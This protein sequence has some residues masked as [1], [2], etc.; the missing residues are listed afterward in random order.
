MKKVSTIIAS[1]TMLFLVAIA[2]ASCG[3]ALPSSSYEK[4]QFAFNGVEK[5]LKSVKLSSD[6]IN[7]NK[8]NYSKSNI[9]L[10]AAKVNADAYSV[11]ENLYEDSD[12]QGDIID[13]LEYNQ[14]PMIQ[15][16]YLKAILDDTGSDFE[17]GT[18]YYSNITN[19]IYYDIETGKKKANTETNYK[20]DYD[21]KLALE[22]NIDSNDLITCD[23]SFDVKLTKGST[24][25]NMDWYVGMELDYD[26]YDKNPNYKLNMLTDD[27]NIKGE[28]ILENDYVEVKNSKI[29]E[30]RK[31]VLE[32][33]RK[34]VKDSSHPNFDSYINEGIEYT[35]GHLKW[36][37]NSN[38][39]KL[40]DNKGNNKRI[41]ANALFNAGLNVTDINGAAFTN[42]NGTE[43][44]KIKTFYN[45][46][47][48]ISGSDIIY[49]LLPDDDKD[50]EKDKT[51][52]AGIIVM[53]DENT[54]FGTQNYIVKNVSMNELF[55]DSEAWKNQ[56]QDKYILPKIYYTNADGEILDRI[57]DLTPFRYYIVKGNTESLVSNGSLIADIYQQFD[58]PEMVDI[59][60]V[61]GDYF[62]FIKDV[63]FTESAYK[64][65][66]G[67]KTADMK[68]LVEAGFPAFI[69]E[70]ITIAK[71]DNNDFTI[72]DSTDKERQLYYD[73]LKNY[74]FFRADSQG[75]Y[76]VKEAEEKILTVRCN[77]DNDVLA[78]NTIDGNPYEE[79]NSNKTKEYLGGIEIQQVTGEKI[80]IEYRE[81]QDNTK[82]IQIWNIQYYEKQNYLESIINNNSDY[83]YDGGY[84][85]RYRIPDDA[86]DIYYEVIFESVDNDGLIIKCESYDIL[87]SKITIDGKDYPASIDYTEHFPEY[88]F[89][90]PY[91]AKNTVIT[92]APINFDVTS[93][94]PNTTTDNFTF[95]GLTITPTYYEMAKYKFTF[96]GY[97]KEE[98]IV[99]LG[100][101][102]EG[103]YSS[104][105]FMLFREDKNNPGQY[106]QIGDFY[107]DSQYKCFIS[108]EV[109]LE[110]GTQL[111]V[112][113]G[114]GENENFTFDVEGIENGIVKTY[115][116]YRFAMYASNPNVVVVY[117]N[118]Y[119][120]GA[121]KDQQLSLVVWDSD[122]INYT[123][124]GTFTYDD[125]R[126]IVQV[127]LEAD[128]VI[129]VYDQKNEMPINDFVFNVEGIESGFV[130]TTGT[131]NLAIYKNNPK[132]VVLFS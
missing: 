86:N 42:K 7:F 28:C 121:F 122:Y 89:V 131:Y 40:M 54:S 35:V 67:Q 103:E 102:C 60:L 12:S 53:L 10:M 63:K 126:F 56:A 110:V 59:K 9:V 72:A 96:G 132:V 75:D 116:N 58:K 36:Y 87:R 123:T 101:Y 33:D 23:V 95:S 128:D 27:K 104:N 99:Y 16:Q 34:V 21:F 25:Y 39:R 24:E 26:M 115:G 70:K 73:S 62:T 43:N 61:H 85:L 76:F 15:F 114:K 14:P 18:K 20:W 3:D 112:K 71:N 125:N 38:L 8:S 19:S 94:E 49:S 48:R 79:W 97:Y 52:P 46:F 120:G 129:A 5:S 66:D 82:E 47:S 22:I 88:Y 109:Y 105:N 111:Y 1:I 84:G 37:K 117:E 29:T 41:A 77:W 30:W 11:I 92:F 91:V 45:E 118:F 13:E 57:T 2:L 74:G 124:V 55:T 81:N 17:F 50:P 4:V 106:M 32:S 69:G 78:F 93:V 113:N 80:H 44:D 65:D 6:E 98:K 83:V 68:E 31:F 108:E 90:T 51:K 127:N 119:N 64:R 130:W 100:L 107:Y